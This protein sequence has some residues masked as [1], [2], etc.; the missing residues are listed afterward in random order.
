L[1]QV[2]LN[3]V[4]QC[5]G[6]L[7][8]SLQLKRSPKVTL[9]DSTSALFKTFDNSNTGSLSLDDLYILCEFLGVKLERKYTLRIFKA[10]DKGNS[11][12]IA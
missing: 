8:K 11:G 9:E 1:S 6:N 3:S 4:N 2:D 5:L 10:I 7:K 12:F